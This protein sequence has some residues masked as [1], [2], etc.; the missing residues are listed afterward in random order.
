MFPGQNPNNI[1]E[2]WE[3]TDTKT[4]ENW[5][6]I[7]NFENKWKNDGTIWKSVYDYI[8]NEKGTPMVQLKK[9]SEL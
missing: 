8:I 9:M 3:E 1:L 6:G 4:F 7:N 2:Q 5:V